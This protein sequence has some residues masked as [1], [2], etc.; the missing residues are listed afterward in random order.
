MYV[1]VKELIEKLKNF[2]ERYQEDLDEDD[3]LLLAIVLAVLT[4]IE[5]EENK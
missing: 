4:N 1:D 2:K 5:K 3:D